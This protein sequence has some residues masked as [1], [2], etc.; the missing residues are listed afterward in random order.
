MVD[1]SAPLGVGCSARRC[2]LGYCLSGLL[3][4]K[5]SL[6]R[7]DHPAGSGRVVDEPV[8]PRGHCRDEPHRVVCLLLPQPCLPHAAAG[9]GSAL[10]RRVDGTLRG[11]CCVYDVCDHAAH[12]AFP[13]RVPHA[14]GSAQCLTCAGTGRGLPSPGLLLLLHD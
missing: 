8:A 12:L 9:G 5:H 3:R 1:A 6:V 10:R 11:G 2:C 14:R 7:S 13:L 4:G